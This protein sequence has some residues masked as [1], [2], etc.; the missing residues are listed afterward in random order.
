M[1]RSSYQI[2]QS[3]RRGQRR[4]IVSPS[5][6]HPAFHYYVDGSAPLWPDPPPKSVVKS[7][8]GPRRITRE[9]GGERG[10]QPI[11]VFWAVEQ[12]DYIPGKRW[13]MIGFVCTFAARIRFIWKSYPS[14]KYVLV[15]ESQSEF[16]LCWRW[17]LIQRLMKLCPRKLDHFS[18][19][20]REKR[21]S[22]KSNISPRQ[23]C[24]LSTL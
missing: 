4:V 16:D 12:V 23:I 20:L 21:Q 19:Y 6:I 3:G 15:K 1:D 24:Y 9:G 11:H 13:G 18:N 7:L 14:D 8:W 22:H 10:E 2:G 5:M 17:L